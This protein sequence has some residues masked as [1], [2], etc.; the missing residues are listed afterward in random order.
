MADAGNATSMLGTMADAAGKAAV[1]VP[2][3]GWAAY[4][5]MA[6]WLCVLVGVLLL[7]FYLLRRFGPRGLARGRGGETPVL[8]GRLV[9]GNRQSVAVVRVLDRILVLGVTEGSVNLLAEDSSDKTLPEEP[10]D[11]A[12]LL[13]WKKDE[14]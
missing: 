11:F 4:W 13:N 3:T 14:R 9:L 2:D 7:G 5:N 1:Q 10:S 8:L 12:E 6:M